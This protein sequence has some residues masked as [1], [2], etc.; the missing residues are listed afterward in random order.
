MPSHI[1]INQD[2]NTEKK[3]RAQHFIGHM[4]LLRKLIGQKH[5]RLLVHMLSA[6]YHESS[7][8]QPKFEGLDWCGACV[9]RY[10]SCSVMPFSCCV[11]HLS[12]PNTYALPQTT[13]WITKRKHIKPFYLTVLC[14]PVLCC[15]PAVCLSSCEKQAT[16][17]ST[18]TPNTPKI[19]IAQN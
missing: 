16:A 3:G 1:P 4:G 8:T 13:F 17:H 19:R 15:V 11:H 7:S 18:G 12:S 14:V 9:L 10:V 5:E 6:R 2:L